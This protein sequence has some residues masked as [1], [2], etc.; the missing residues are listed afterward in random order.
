MDE[1]LVL[2]GNALAG[3]LAELFP[4][5]MTV[6]QGTCR[7]CGRV[8]PLAEAQVYAHAPGAVVRC[9]GCASVLFVISKDGDRY[10]LGFDR[11][12]CLELRSTA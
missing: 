11:L 5:E 2:D 1:E 8:G 7:A 3:V 4:F 9:A 6:A 12:R 10:F